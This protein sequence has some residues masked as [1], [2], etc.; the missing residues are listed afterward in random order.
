M[1]A[2]FSDFFSI[3]D[4]DT[5]GAENEQVYIVSRMSANPD[6]YILIKPGC[7]AGQYFSSF[8]SAKSV[9]PSGAT[10]VDAT[11]LRVANA[12]NIDCAALLSGSHSKTMP[13]GREDAHL[14][15]DGSFTT[16]QVGTTTSTEEEGSREVSG[17]GGTSAPTPDGWESLDDTQKTMI[18]GGGVAALGLLLLLKGRRR[19]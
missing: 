11:N 8:E 10:I 14:D 18:I 15:D 3:G 19:D 6:S 9:I 7:R 4:S 5:F 12:N 2:V 16:G 17:N 13:G 1:G